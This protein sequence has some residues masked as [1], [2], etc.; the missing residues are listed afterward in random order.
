M[1]ALVS[2]V[3][4]S[5]HTDWKH[6][7]YADRWSFWCLYRAACVYRIPLAPLFM[8]N[9]VIH[10]LSEIFCLTSF[11]HSTEN[12]CILHYLPS[13]YSCWISHVISYFISLHLCVRVQ[14]M[15]AS[16]QICVTNSDISSYT[17]TP[18]L[19]FSWLAQWVIQYACYI[20]PDMW[21]TKYFQ[22]VC[23]FLY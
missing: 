9:M 19:E 14:K 12:I 5:V 6:L 15:K 11:F 8:T 4:P 21:I 23:M 22:A 7:F 2:S 13:F 10:N 1:G 20:I 17:A 3:S 18:S 16:W